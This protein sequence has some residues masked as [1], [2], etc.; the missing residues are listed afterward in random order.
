MIEYTL[1]LTGGERGF[2]FLGDSS[3][4]L[5]LECALNREGEQ[6]VDHT[7]ISHSIVRDAAE[8]GQ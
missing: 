6:I 5:K 7:K 8:S 1:R 4:T 3:T 2:V